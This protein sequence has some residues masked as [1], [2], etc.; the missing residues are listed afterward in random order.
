MKGEIKMK[1][2]V[3]LVAFV[4][5]VS[6]LMTSC[7]QT[8]FE[9]FEN[10][11]FISSAKVGNL[12]VKA[13]DDAPKVYAI[14]T[15]TAKP[16]DYTIEVTY[17]VDPSL[18]AHY[19]E[20]Y[21]AETVLLPEEYYEVSDVVSTIMPGS[22]AGNDVMVTFTGL[23]DLDRDYVYLLPITIADANIP[24]LE[25]ARTTYFVVKAAALINVVANLSQNY[26]SLTGASTM[27]G[28]TD[29]T[30]EALIRP[31]DFPNMLSTIM[32][33]EGAFLL[34]VGD[35]GIPPNQV[36]LAMS[37]NVTDASW[38]IPTKVWTHIALTYSRT[39]REVNLYMDGVRKGGTKTNVAQT[40]INWT[41]SAP[42][43]IGKAWDDGRWLEGEASE[44]RVWNR[45][46]T[47]EEINEK[48]HFY[49]VDPASPGL[50]AYWK[51]DEGTGIVVKDHTG[52]GHDVIAN[53]MITWKEVSLP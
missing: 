25:S 34:R 17:K 42:F 18:V 29:I 30:I 4:F 14:N 5:M 7:N 40:T 20:A 28:L 11:A 43:L 23:A 51:F 3:K 48:N 35:A 38:A 24:V 9:N 16:E 15:S 39:T 41:P 13:G 44:Y 37:T 12:L 32:G 45:V 19:N 8:N 47:I 6:F 21:Y 36:Q 49:Q 53:S 31:D 46:L 33:V 27:T 2:Y 10:K 26:L 52:N 1:N 22:V 50:I